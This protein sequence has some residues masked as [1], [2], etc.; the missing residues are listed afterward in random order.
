MFLGI[1]KAKVDSLLLCFSSS[2]TESRKPPLSLLLKSLCSFVLYLRIILCATARV[3]RSKKQPFRHGHSQSLALTS[4]YM[5]ENR[6]CTDPLPGGLESTS[7]DLVIPGC[8][9]PLALALENPCCHS[10]KP[11]SFGAGQGAD[12][13]PKSPPGNAASAREWSWTS[14]PHWITQ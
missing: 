4:G 3:N 13:E 7:D 5:C 2:T 1:S 8:P 9:N 6:G 12:Y 14:C 10:R 11:D